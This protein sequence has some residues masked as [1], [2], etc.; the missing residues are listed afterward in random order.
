M[1]R[2]ACIQLKRLPRPNLSQAL[3]YYSYTLVILYAYV[4]LRARIEISMRSNIQP[5]R[6][7]ETRAYPIA[8]SLDVY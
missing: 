4:I 7:V 1:L 6:A 8:M 2:Q 3:F 5:S